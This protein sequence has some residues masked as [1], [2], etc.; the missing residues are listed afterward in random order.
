MDK[1]LNARVTPT[2]HAQ[3]KK[4]SS[5][6]KVIMNT[7][8]ETLLEIGLKY[9]PDKSIAVDSNSYITKDDL[10]IFET[11]LLKK[12]Q[13]LITNSARVEATPKDSDRYEDSEANTALSPEQKERVLNEVKKIATDSDPNLSLSYLE[14][15]DLESMERNELRK[16]YGKL[17][18]HKER[19]HAV[20]SISKRD[21]ILEITNY[22][23]ILKRS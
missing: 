15:L 6:S 8:V 5:E 16:L 1:Q 17:Y 20:N 3:I 12:V 9:Y 22:I 21:A 13:S 11:E 2:I 4:L 7:L 23:N 14:S 18:N 10:I 19:T